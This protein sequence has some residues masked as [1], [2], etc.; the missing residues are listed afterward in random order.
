MFNDQSIEQRT[1]DSTTSVVL[2]FGS[3][4]VTCLV[5]AAVVL[6][7]SSVVMAGALLAVFRTG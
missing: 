7:A 5:M 6:Q 4:A 3:I 1:T 2:L